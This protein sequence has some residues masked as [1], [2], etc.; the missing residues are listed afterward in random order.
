MAPSGVDF[1]FLLSACAVL[2]QVWN[3]CFDVTPAKLIEGIITDKGVLTKK[4]GVF[5]VP[6]FMQS[7]VTSA[8]LCG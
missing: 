7:Q 2:L 8:V 4:H 1:P 6:A 5:D 3:P